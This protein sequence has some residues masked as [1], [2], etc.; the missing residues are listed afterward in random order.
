ME[1]K[2]AFK[3]ALTQFSSVLNCYLNIRSICVLEYLKQF[4]SQLVAFDTAANYWRIFCDVLQSA[5]QKTRQKTQTNSRECAVQTRNHLYHVLRKTKIPSSWKGFTHYYPQKFYG[6][7]LKLYRF[8]CIV[9]QLSERKAS[10]SLGEREMLWE[11]EPPGE[12][13]AHSVFLIFSPNG[14][15]SVSTRQKLNRNRGNVTSIAY[16]KFRDKKK[17][18]TCLIWA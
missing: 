12:C 1:E 17:L 9:F 2:S 8:R 7:H 11:H 4:S 5:K 16:R 18:T 10:G 14:F 15:T 13:F 3:R 6:P